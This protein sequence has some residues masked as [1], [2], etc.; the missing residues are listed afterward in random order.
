M[1]DKCQQCGALRPKGG[2][3]KVFVNGDGSLV[4]FCTDKP[5]C[6]DE[7]ILT[8]ANTGETITAK[9]LA[10]RCEREADTCATHSTD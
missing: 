5:K 10:D 1:A 2:T 6:G 9:E 8:N 4:E 3:T 7:F